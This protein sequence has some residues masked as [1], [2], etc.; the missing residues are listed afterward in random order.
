MGALVYFVNS[1]KKE[2]FCPLASKITE[3]YCNPIIMAGIIDTL[4]SEWN[5]DRIHIIRDTDDDK[6]SK[7]I[8]YKE[9]EIRW[10]DYKDYI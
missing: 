9:I 2:Y 8:H 3:V 4:D 7:I 10:S 1:T 6:M 5:G